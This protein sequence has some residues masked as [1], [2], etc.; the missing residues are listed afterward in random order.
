MR[1]APDVICIDFETKGI[2]A[3]PLY[4]PKPVSLALKWPG[5]K[6]YKLMAW[7]HE[8]GGNNCT[9]KEARSELDK[10]RR[11]RYPLLCQFGMFDHDV[12]ET[13]WDMPLLPWERCHDTMFLLF[14]WDPHAPSLALKESAERLLG[15]KPEE[16]DKLREWILA[17]V[18]E[19][20]RKP[21][22]WGAY[23]WKAP[24]QIVRPYHKGDL[25][26][27]QGIFDFLHPRIVDAGMEEA[28]QRDQRLMPVLLKNA[29]RGM[30]VDVE[31]LDRD[32]PVLRKGLEK[33]DAWLRKRL[34][35]INLNSDKQLGDAL[36]DKG[37]VKHFKLTPKGQR[38]VGK[39]QLTI[40]MFTDKK[41]YQTLTY[42]SQMETS[43]GTFMEPWRELAGEG[44]CIYP[45]WAQVRSP[46]GD[47]RDTKG[48]RSGRIICSRPNFL[49]IPKKWKKS[50][51]AGYVHPTWLGVPELPYIRTYALPHKGK[52]WGRRD[53]NQ[54]E[55]RLFAYYEEGP[56]QDGFLTDP[57]YDIHELVREECER[58]LVEAAL[59]DSFDRDTAKNCVF[60]RLYGQG[61]TGLMETL[62]LPD[63]ERVVAQLVQKAINTAVPSIKELDGIL[64][65]MVNSGAP[66]K[67]WG[68]RLYYVEEPKYVEK[69]GRNMDFAYKMLNYLCQGSGAD[70]TKEVLCRYDEHPKRQE[71]FIVTVY[72]EIDTD[73]PLSD[74][75]ARQEMQVL[76]E[77]M[78]SIDVDPMKMNSDGEVGPNWGALQKFAV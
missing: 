41:V 66:I 64:K 30:R 58:A 33:A 20:K 32:I 61:I 53:F 59:R 5:Q 42:K 75:G 60:A 73:L 72:D 6:E 14:L 78:L 35:D 55:L 8:A 36:Y 25:V 56:V 70:V 17:N 7:G 63:D 10:A 18:P 11:S 19:A 15:I 39:K 28:Y 43:I 77:C 71:D 52:R 38:G 54:Q 2:E 16:Q 68:G 45:V 50:M 3:R 40:D 29:R 27:T 49:N 46:K 22:T 31:G 67:T 74:K 9:E 51:G 76:K 57:K 4:P 47:T 26:R 44:D 13:H 37:I 62:K 24:Y 21:S 65:E 34:G 23:I 12:A 1:K 48:A 69:F